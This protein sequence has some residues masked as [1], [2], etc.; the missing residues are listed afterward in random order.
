MPQLPVGSHLLWGC[1]RA[2]L[3]VQTGRSVSGDSGNVLEG[4][5]PV[6][7]EN[8]ER[9]PKIKEF[10]QK[11]VKEQY[12]GKPTNTSRLAYLVKL[13]DSTSASDAQ[14]VCRSYSS[15]GTKQR[16]ERWALEIA[17][18]KSVSGHPNIVKFHGAFFEDCASPK[19]T[20]RCSLVMEWCRRQSL[21]DFIACQYQ[22]EWQNVKHF[23]TD[24][25]MGLRHIHQLSILHRD[26]KPANCLLQPVQNE[27]NVLKICDFSKAVFLTHAWEQRFPN[28][29]QLSPFFRTYR[30]ASPEVATKQPYG[31]P[32][33]MWSVGVILWELLQEDARVP[34]VNFDQKGENLGFV[35]AALITFCKKL[36]N[37]RSDED[38]SP[39]ERFALELLSLAADVRPCAAQAV[40]KLA[41]MG[42]RDVGFEEQK[43]G[44]DEATQGQGEEDVAGA[45]LEPSSNQVGT[46]LEPPF[47]YKDCELLKSS[48]TFKQFMDTH[49]DV[50]AFVEAAQNLG[51]QQG[52]I[53]LLYTL[54]RVM[55]P[56]VVRDLGW[57]FATLPA[58]FSAVQFKMACHAAILHAASINETETLQSEML[59]YDAEQSGCHM[60]LACTMEELGLLDAANTE[61]MPFT[62]QVWLGHSLHRKRYVLACDME[63]LGK[64]VEDFGLVY[65]AAQG[66]LTNNSLSAMVNKVSALFEGGCVRTCPTKAVIRK[67]LAS[68][69]KPSLASG[70]KSKRIPYSTLAYIRKHMYWL[71]LEHEK[72]GSCQVDFSALLLRD[73]VSLM[74]LDEIEQ[75]QGISWK[76]P[77]EPVVEITATDTPSS[78]PSDPGGDVRQLP[79]SAP[80]APSAPG[81]DG[82]Q[83]APSAQSAESEKAALDARKRIAPSA[84]GGK[85]KR[86]RAAALTFASDNQ[87][88]QS[89]RSC[90]KGGQ[91][92]QRK[93]HMWYRIACAGRPEKKC[94]CKGN[95][96]SRCPARTKLECP[97]PASWNVKMVGSEYHAKVPLCSACV[98]QTP[99]CSTNARRPYGQYLR[100]LDNIGRCRACWTL[101]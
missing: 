44:S 21:R 96:S 94:Q 65:I 85:L 58:D 51:K 57:R 4:I 18:H 9:G 89:G 43:V 31:L 1:R 75:L 7:L 77:I 10:H 95:C 25:C 60:G 61:G 100:N 64:V 42:L 72:A 32:S 78:A 35:V 45:K 48:A 71:V 26:M 40:E 3:G 82:T 47:Q 67:R 80:P 13:R 76:V 66:T 97:N 56:T 37:R 55:Y 29:Q 33:D 88:G 101:P 6:W 41:S 79:P 16:F 73:V 5:D 34:A 38:V 90:A 50:I 20:A 11:Y 93:V 52:N 74:R 63:L 28:S 39:L 54:S 98:C 68:K 23:A 53:L 46:N 8:L 84:K 99:Q 24:M 87:E 86:R 62:K 30:Y 19:I 12:L 70:G 81:G 2:D 15:C 49:G 59:I 83:P 69:T 91:G 22:L 17:I 92:A 36:D 14:R 27:L